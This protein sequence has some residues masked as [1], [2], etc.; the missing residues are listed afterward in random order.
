MAANTL[1]T[2]L[3]DVEQHSLGRS[4]VLHLLPGLLILAFFVAIAPLVVSLGYPSLMALLL[5]ITVVLIPLELGYLLYLGYRANGRLSLQ[6]IVV[7]REPTPFWQRVLMALLLWGW[8]GLGIAVTGPV[9]K[10]LIERFFSWLP[11]WF[12]INGFVA[13]A[14]DYSRQ[15]L[16]TTWIV[17]MV[18]NGVLGPWVEEL[19]FRGY[20]LPRLAWLKGWAPAVS[21]LLF[22]LYHFFTPWQNVGRIVA[23]GP[24]VY[25]VWRKKDIR[26]G[27]FSHMLGNVS[28]LLGWVGLLLR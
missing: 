1:Q 21:V 3:A 27:L 25:T 22:S 19:Y 17:G 14:G 9:D 11:E 15:A 13:H 24:M 6:G 18:F 20:L 10:V 2:V 8:A 23:F 4:L 28:G 5:A 12:F 16:W 26:I 7:Y